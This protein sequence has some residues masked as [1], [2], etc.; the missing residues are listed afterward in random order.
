MTRAPVSS[1]LMLHAKNMRSQMTGPELKLW[2][3]LRAHRLM[4]LSFRRQVPIGN[5]IADFVC[6][7]HKIIIEVDGESHSHDDA[8]L[9]DKKR[10]AFLEKEGWEIIRFTNDEVLSA[11]DE[12][13]SHII[14]CL[15][16]KGVTFS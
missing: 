4:G 7:A 10:T 11:S 9:K 8:I 12:C 15:E 16:Q 5:Y 14:A 6:P 3:E 13:C 2:N 1:R